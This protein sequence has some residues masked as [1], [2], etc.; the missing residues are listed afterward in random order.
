V[1]GAAGGHGCGMSVPDPLI[2]THLVM[3]SR[4]QLQAVPAPDG[5]LSVRRWGQVDVRFY[6]FLYQTVGHDLRWRD[7]LIMPESELA[8]AL[9]AAELHVL[10]VGGVPAGYIELARHPDGSLEIAYFGLRPEYHGRG[11][12]KYL[13]SYG[14]ARAWE[15]DPTHVH[16]HTC[17]LD[18]AYALQTYLARGFEV[19]H[20]EQEPMPDRYRA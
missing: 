3:R 13:L 10:T 7:R 18:G 4:G 8:A 2:T 11:L 20:V 14:V 19:S 9:A 6:L 12:G 5:D 1:G 15:L 17:N 16:L